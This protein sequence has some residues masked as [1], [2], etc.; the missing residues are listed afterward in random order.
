MLEDRGVNGESCELRIREGSLRCLVF[1]GG[2][3]ANGDVVGFWMGWV[4]WGNMDI[5]NVR[6]IR[7]M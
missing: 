5:F 6:V 2:K 7:L 3:V 1:M 4:F